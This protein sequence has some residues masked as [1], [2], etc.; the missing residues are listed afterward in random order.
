MVAPGVGSWPPALATIRAEVG[1]GGVVGLATATLP[2]GVA[3]LLALCAL[4]PG[5][6]PRFRPGSWK[7]ALH[8]VGARTGTPNLQRNN[9]TVS[10]VGT[11]T[12]SHV[13]TIGHLNHVPPTL[14]SQTKRSEDVEG[15]TVG[16]FDPDVFAQRSN[17]QN[18]AVGQQ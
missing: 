16:E 14:A 4:L 6:G 11:I 18:N 7:R 13:D 9:I 2:S 5:P 1:L 3:G 17:N 10:H 15:V 12:I 8:G